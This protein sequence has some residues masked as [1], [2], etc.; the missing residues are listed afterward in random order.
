[1][2]AL[3]EA[4]ASLQQAIQDANTRFQNVGE[5]ET[6]LA[7]E[8]QKYDELVA[9]EEA[10]DV[11]QNQELTEARAATDDA[12]AQL[13]SVADTLSG[14][15]EQVNT[16]GQTVTESP[17]AENPDQSATAT[18]TT[19]ASPPA[20]EATG[21]DTGTADTATGET[22]ADDE[23][24]TSEAAAD[25]ATPGGAGTDEPV[26]TGTTTQETAGEADDPTSTMHMRPE[27]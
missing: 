23:S 16:L 21:A 15:T 6:A 9:A 17:N 7:A 10:E 26:G 11:Q 22:P 4:V 27:V 24:Q 2:A 18:E 1:M 12:V 8:R 3:E 20:T 25:A 14:L 19:D 13:S 5:L